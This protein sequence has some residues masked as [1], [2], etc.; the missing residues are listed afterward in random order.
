MRKRGLSAWSHRNRML[1]IVA[2]QLALFTGAFAYAGARGVALFALEGLVTIAMLK[3]M[4]YVQHYGL[5]RR[6]GQDGKLEPVSSL[7]AWDS[8]TVLTNHALFNLGFHSRHH[9]SPGIAYHE[10][11][12]ATRWHELPVGYSA[13]MMLALVPPVWDRTMERLLDGRTPRKAHSASF[14]LPAASCV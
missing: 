8:L 1:R 5:V 6:T 13:M 2:M 7:H 10:L 4:N 12:N 11:P 14:W 3:W 9:H